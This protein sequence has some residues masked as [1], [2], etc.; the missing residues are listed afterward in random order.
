[1][2]ENL[3]YDIG[4]NNGDDTRYYL[5]LGYNVIAVEAS[6]DLVNEVLCHFKKE[7][8]E[9]K[10]EILNVGIASEE[11]YLDFY[12][13]KHDSVWNSFDKTLGSRGGAGFEIVKVKTKSLD[14]LIDEKGMPYYLKIDIE[15][16]D[17][18]AL[19]GLVKYKAKP[20]YL[21]VELYDIDLIIMLGNL[22]YTNFK[23][24]DQASFLPLEMPPVKEYNIYKRQVRFRSSMN[25]LT[26]ATRKLF[27]RFINKWFEKKYKRLFNYNHP[28]GSSG[29]FGKNL[30][31]KWHNLDEIKDVFLRYKDSF[32]NSKGC[33]SN[34]WWIDIHATY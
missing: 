2:N 22:G 29:S 17:R 4:M 23:I 11:G 26:R 3:V 13:N 24:I 34:G 7:I 6:P 12:L 16:Y 27:G 19:S 25:I 10:L 18:V 1:M 33:K 14:Q 31:G 8:Q 15:G 28:V 32:E 5:S 9:K 30:P 21:S 20:K